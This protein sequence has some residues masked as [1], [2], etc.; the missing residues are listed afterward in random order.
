MPI[1]ALISAADFMST[2]SSLAHGEKSV[3]E[4]EQMLSQVEHI[5][6]IINC[7]FADFDR[8]LFGFSGLG[9]V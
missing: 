5:C 2:A 1:H 4:L 9:I 6:Q 3:A 8:L 7:H